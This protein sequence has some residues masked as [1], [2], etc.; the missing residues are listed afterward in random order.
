MKKKLRKITLSRE[1][2]RRLD[3][4][5]LKEAAVGGIAQ[6]AAEAGSWDRTCQSLCFV[7]PDTWLNTQDNQ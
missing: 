6:N 5:S 7:C 3:E 1:T 4:S 2:L